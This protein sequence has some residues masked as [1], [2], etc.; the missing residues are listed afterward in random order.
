MMQSTK[1]YDRLLIDFKIAPCVNNCVFC[2]AGDDYKKIATVPFAKVKPIVEKLVEW[3]KV[4]ASVG[5]KMFIN[6][7]NWDHKDIADNI[8][9]DKLV[10]N[11]SNGGTAMLGGVKHR[12]EP[13]MREKLAFLKEAGMEAIGITF[14]GPRELHDGW[15]GRRGE[16]DFNMMAAR[17][18]PEIGLLRREHLFLVKSSLP[19]LETIMDI[20]DAIPGRQ[21]RYVLPL[22]YWGRAMKLE[23]ERLT[24]AEFDLIPDRIRKYIRTRDL[25]TEEEWMAFVQHDWDAKKMAKVLRMLISRD[26]IAELEKL[27]A[28]EIMKSLIVKFD[29]VYASL[30]DFREMGKPYGDSSNDKIYS[31][32]DIESKWSQYYYQDHPAVLPAL[33]KVPRITLPPISD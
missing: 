26:N 29:M 31:L 8:R 22:N 19:H 24:K 11:S 28:D 27:S 7:G 2:H 1:D 13:E 23:H 25:R 5:F 32:Y 33:K 9:L 16:Y 12:T 17:F 15:C 21:D 30:P 18:A 3:K 10:R 6:P 4:H 14:W 20:L